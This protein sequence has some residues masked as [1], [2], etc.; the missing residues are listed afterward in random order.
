MTSPSTERL[1]VHGPTLQDLTDFLLFDK[2]IYPV[3]NALKR[4]RSLAPGYAGYP[5]EEPVPQT[6]KERLKDS[7]FMVAPGAVLFT[8]SADDFIAQLQKGP[9]AVMEWAQASGMDVGRILGEIAFSTLHTPA[10]ESD[11]ATWRK[12]IDTKI[13]KLADLLVQRNK[14]VVPRFYAEDVAKTLRPGWNLVLSVTFRQFPGVQPGR[15]DIEK[16]VEFLSHEQTKERRRRLFDWPREIAAAVADGKL[17]LDTIPA[18]IAQLLADYS[19]WIMQSGLASKPTVAEFL[20]NFDASFVGG[21]TQV[22][23]GEDVSELLML[24]PRGLTL[25]QEE[26]ATSGQEL[27]YISHSKRGY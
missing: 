10:S 25:T 8:P 21:L 9:D 20:V 18:H 16:F 4:P 15:F 22:K 27:A 11:A 12:D 3:T 17:S 23:V 19:S 2:V 6:I 26:Q 13:K 1:L 24:A 5:L 14:R 7:G